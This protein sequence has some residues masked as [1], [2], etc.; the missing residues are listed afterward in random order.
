MNLYLCKNDIDEYY[1]VAKN[2]TDAAKE[3]EEILNNN[4]Y[5]LSFQREV[6][7]IKLLTKEILRSD[8]KENH[9]LLIVSKETKNKQK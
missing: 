5:G 2:Y 8:F 4:N 3:L 1:V 7:E 6:S 9:K